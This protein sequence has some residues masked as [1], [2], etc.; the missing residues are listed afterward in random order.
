[1]QARHRAGWLLQRVA[2]CAFCL[3][4]ALTLSHAY[5]GVI[6][7]VN[8]LL[9]VLGLSIVGGAV[10]GLGVHVLDRRKGHAHPPDD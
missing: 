4:V 7:T 8:K 3:Y 10:V 2:W 9:I 6:L 1:M 5:A